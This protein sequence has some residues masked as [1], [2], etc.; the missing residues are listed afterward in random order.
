[1]WHCLTSKIT[2]VSCSR[3]KLLTR[4]NGEGQ[5]SLMTDP[6]T[7]ILQHA[8]NHK[9][10]APPATTTTYNASSTEE[11]LIRRGNTVPSFHLKN[12]SRFK[13]EIPPFAEATGLFHSADCSHRRPAEKHDAYYVSLPSY[14]TTTAIRS[15]LRIPGKT[16]NNA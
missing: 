5:N 11:A 3:H 4:D 9:L 12:A 16:Y 2:A 6:T 14:G 8:A 13:N 10:D 7:T 15:R 1:M